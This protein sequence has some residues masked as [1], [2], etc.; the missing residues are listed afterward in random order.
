MRILLELSP[1]H[2][3]SPKLKRSKQSLK[4]KSKLFISL[5]F[6]LFVILRKIINKK[7]LKKQNDNDYSPSSR[8]L[9]IQRI[10]HSQLAKVI[11][12]FLYRNL[13]ANKHSYERTCRL[14]EHRCVSDGRTDVLIGIG[15][16]E[17]DSGDDFDTEW[18]VYR[19]QESGHTTIF[20]NQIS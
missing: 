7:L 14:L 15:G 1:K 18:S 5:K 10:N 6:K 12:H 16:E 9:L 13:F 3:Q 11:S 2:Y 8:R 17:I 19:D 4:K 20:E